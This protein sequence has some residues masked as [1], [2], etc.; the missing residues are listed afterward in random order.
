MRQ[1]APT[2]VERSCKLCG[3]WVVADHLW[4]HNCARNRWVRAGRAAGE[5]VGLPVRLGS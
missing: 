5:Q 3:V 1:R 4:W 2:S